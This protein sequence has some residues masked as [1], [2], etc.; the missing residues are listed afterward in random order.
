[1]LVV[2]PLEV[3]VADRRSLTAVPGKESRPPL[4]LTGMSDLHDDFKPE[5]SALEQA[6]PSLSAQ[7]LDGVKARVRRRTGRASAWQRFARTRGTIVAAITAGVLMSTGGTALGISGLASSGVASTAQY[8]P[9][10]SGSSTPSKS[11]AVSPIEAAQQPAVSSSGEL[12]FTGF[13]AIPV[14]LIGV[15]LVGVG[16]VGRRSSAR[17]TDVWR[18]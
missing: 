10:G 9:A 1:V 5:I 18:N 8:S 2:Q 17:E 15:G 4:V 11:A 6:R 7:E 13:L 12:P 16:L 14:F 3:S